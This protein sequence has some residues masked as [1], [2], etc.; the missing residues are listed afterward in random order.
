MTAEGHR[1]R[2]VPDLIWYVAYGSNM[3]FTRLAYYLR[4]G[5]PPDAARVYPGCRDKTLPARTMP[6]VLRGGLAFAL[7]SAVWTGGQAFFDRGADT[8]TPGRAYLL[9]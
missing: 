7:E 1:S 2:G 3:H 4:G 9:T 6:V 5:R 8:W